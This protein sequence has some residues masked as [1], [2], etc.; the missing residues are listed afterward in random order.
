MRLETST[1]SITVTLTTRSLHSRQ[2]THN[3]PMQKVL[4]FLRLGPKP[5]R[6]K[7]HIHEEQDAAGGGPGGGP[8]VGGATDGSESA[9]PAAASNKVEESAPKNHADGKHVATAHKIRKAEPNPLV[10][11]PLEEFI[12]RQTPFAWERLTANIFP[13]GTTPGCVVASPSKALPDYWYQWTRDSAV[14]ERVIVERYVDEGR[15]EDWKRLEEYVEASRIMQHKQTVLGGFQNGGL[16][17]V[18]YHGKSICQARW[19]L[20]AR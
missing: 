8:G 1:S 11:L 18:K 12:A 20:Q 15:A 19:R 10:K 3:G 14:C 7:S 5:V 6:R 13:E 2:Q 9:T 4:R 16:G 17:E